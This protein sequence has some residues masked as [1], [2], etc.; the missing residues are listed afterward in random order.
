M[1]R[2]KTLLT[3]ILSYILL[4][5]TGCIS[6]AED[7][8]PPPGSE[9]SPPPVETL[10]V[11]PTP[12]LG[13]NIFPTNLPDPNQGASIYI[14]KC[15][16]CH[17]ESGKGDGPDSSMLENPVPALGSA[18]L[19]RKSTPSDWYLMITQGNLSNFMPPF[20]SLSDQE[21]WDVVAYLY[22]LSASPEIIAEGESLYTKECAECH[23]D[24]GSQGE[25]NLADQVLMGKR[26]AEDMV[27]AIVNG[28]GE[29]P[30]LDDFNENQ[31]W[32]LT[33][34]LRSLTF[35]PVDSNFTQEITDVEADVQ[36]SDTSKAE[37]VEASDDVNTED[38][39]GN[40]TVS[41]L[42]TSNGTLPND[43][44]VILRGYDDMSEVYT[45]T[46]VL[47]EG[48]KITFGSVPLPPDRMYFATIEFE[49]AVYGSDVQAV[50]VDSP[51]DLN[52]DITYYAPTTDP[53]ILQVDR[54]HV[55]LS[56]VDER[57]LE[58]FQL[59]IF[60]NP[61][62]QILVPSEEGEVAVNFLIPEDSSNL[63]V[64]ENMSLAYK[65]TNNG[66]GIVNVYPD[67]TAYQTV[68]SYQIPYEG[69]KIDLSIP[70]SMN[71]NAVIVMAPA[72]GLR[73]K[74][75]QL[76]DAGSRDFEGVSYNMYT[77]AKIDSGANLKMTLSGRIDTN[78]GIF[79]TSDDSNTNLVIGLAG[80]GTA[81]IVAGVFL[82]YRNLVSEEE[83]M[84]DDWI[85]DFNGETPE[86]LMDAIIT[87]DDQYRTGGL[88]EGAYRVRRAE[89]KD[90]LREIL[91]SD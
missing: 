32:A 19:A 13:E 41:I 67:G 85:D 71:S 11:Q 7:I 23:G 3:I 40:V 34:Y 82:W 4:A 31:L 54:L 89:L 26:T 9:L 48:N 65:V 62:N 37:D 29:M 88:P 18:A 58:I 6:L 75:E 77:G 63:Y 68:F 79:A 27:A 84:E 70:I 49:N 83:E 47:S 5:V 8:T 56:I 60:S 51:E 90:R 24:D 57:T 14:D 73:V 28:Q 86:D 50:Q 76:E 2:L 81:L 78:V 35:A 44:E 17:G 72:T 16:P 43:L 10:E 15:A 53:S 12:I 59:Y 66:F 36:E 61:T 38:K 30:A 74:S 1:T 39:I 33:A 45:Q 64:E 91:G 52:I 42:D 87:I 25:V 80:L 20:S 22:T 55:F 46:L 69:R 21:R